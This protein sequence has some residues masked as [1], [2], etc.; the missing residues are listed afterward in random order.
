MSHLRKYLSISGLLAGIQQ[1]FLR[2][3]EPGYK[4]KRNIKIVD[5]LMSGVA[6][7]GLKFP[8]LLQYDIQK[9][10]PAIEKNLKKLYRIEQAPSDT[11]LRE[12]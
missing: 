1:T 3:P 5:C 9:R 4:E 12:E 10:Y 7:F 6:I 2:V 8:S 11:Y